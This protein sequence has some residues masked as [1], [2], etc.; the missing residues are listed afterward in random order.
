V[1]TAFVPPALDAVIDPFLR[2]A[3]ERFYATQQAED[4]AAYLSLWSTTAQRPRPDQLK[5]I[6]DSGDDQFSGLTI[7]RVATIG[8]RT[9]VRASVVRDRTSSTARRPDGQPV[10]F[11]TVMNVALTFVREGNDWK[12]VREGAAVDTLADAL[13]AAAS[14]EDRDTLIAAEPDLANPTLVSAVSRQADML[15]QS[16]SF[17]RA[18]AL[19]ELALDLATRFE[20]PRMQAEALQN[21]GNAMYYQRNFPG[22]LAA[23]RQR[24]T[25]ERVTGN[26]EGIANALLGI[27]TVQYSQFEYTD[28]LDSYREALAIHERRDDPLA[29]ATTLVSTGNVQFVEG[30]FAGAVADYSR[31]RA[32]FRKAGDKRGETRALEGLGRSFAAQGDFAGALVAYAGVLE[33]GRIEHDRAMQG[34]A[35]SN[36][37]DVHF[38]MGNLDT[39]RGMFD[40]SRTHF[41]SANDLPNVGRAWQAMALTDLASSRFAAAEEEYGRSNAACTTAG[42]NECIARAIV[43]LAFAQAAQEHFEPAIASYRKAIAAFTALKKREDASRAE[44]GLSQA[45]TGSHDYPGA[46]AAAIHAQAE[47]E[48]LGR[49]DVVWRALVAQ[50]RA[51][52]R[53]PDRARA[54]STATAATAIVERMAEAALDRPNEPPAA[55]TES[56][57][58]LLAV[59]QADAGDAPAAFATIERRRTHALR[60]ALALNERDIAR[61]MTST[62]RDEER[63]LA[64]EVVTIRTQVEQTKA[65]PKPDAVR[66]ARLQQ[67]L[68]E[69]VEKRHVVRHEIFARLPELKVWRGLGPTATLKDAESTLRAEGDILAEFVIDDDDLLVVILKRGAEGS[70]CRAYVTPIGRQVLA[71]RIAHA[72]EPAVLRDV[73]KWR[74]AS[75]EL[76][77]AIPPVA[78]SV[79]AAAPQAVLVPDDVLWR[80]PFE[81]LPVE[82]GFLAD[83]TTVLYAGSATSLVNVPAVAARAD[84]TSVVIVGSPELSASTRDRLGITSPGWTLPDSDAATAEA[85]SIAGV[86]EESIASPLAGSSATEAAVRGQMNGATLIHVAA[87]FRM[88]GASPLFS[89]IL[90]TTDPAAANLPADNDGVLE[91]REVMNLDLHARVAVLSDGG[92]ASLRGAAPA[93]EIVRWAWRAAG[94]PSVVLSR[95]RME[96]VESLRLL[97]DLYGRLKKG[98]TPEVALE[99]ARTAVRA[100]TETRAP[101]FWAGWMA[102]GR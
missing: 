64:A 93:A 74:I 79:I 7:L 48:A 76:V 72:V 40:Q 61:G 96:P 86:F 18:Q 62:E 20:Q 66:I 67:A 68:T 6:F 4:V 91:M 71:A 17:A 51:L 102:V 83:R 8:D 2:A 53:T 32:L 41:E 89:P 25:I 101:Y 77:K 13:I 5:F 92:S 12:I 49:D 9:V 60:A 65:L 27:G 45:L 28:A 46:L 21:I 78:W 33:E 59:L 57:Y 95:W 24:L 99:G 98:A 16:R 34:T 35:L 44:L 88:N 36:M 80:V 3:V 30:D 69:A 82:A 90:L 63:R 1:A 73:D 29:T 58:A 94:V 84:G 50:S 39:A 43:G 10:V 31:S 42:D 22:A 26:E 47:G 52:R 97:K 85:R 54:L 23:Y 14:S 81:A 87:P 37:G 100:A 38:R 55:D 11:H 15:A 56:A 75:A 19:Y 70:E